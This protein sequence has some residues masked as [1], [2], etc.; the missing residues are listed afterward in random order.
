MLFCLNL[1][2][3]ALFVALSLTD[4]VTYQLK[5]VINVTLKKFMK[6]MK[7]QP[8]SLQANQRVYDHP[9]LSRARRDVW[10]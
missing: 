1:S 7:T 2:K 5:V 8:H 4:F 6:D 10:D 9:E 3:E